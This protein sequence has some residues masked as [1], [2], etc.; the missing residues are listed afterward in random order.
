MNLLVDEIVS[1]EQLTFSNVSY[2][3]GNTQILKQISVNV[4]KDNKITGIVGPS[5]SG[6]TT[7]LR[8]VN[9]LISP[10]QGEISLNTN[11]HYSTLSSRGLRRK[12][13]FLQQ[14]PSL[15]PGTVKNNVEYGP[16]LWNINLSVK[17]INELLTKV[18]LD[19]LTYLN[20]ETSELSGGEQQRVCLARTLANKPCVLLLDEPTSSL[21]IVSE[22]IVEETLLKLVNEDGI[23]IIIVTHSLE[24]TKRLTDEIIFLKNGTIESQIP[25][26][27]F[28]QTYSEKQ[29]YN[30]FKKEKKSNDRDNKSN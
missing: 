2:S 22:G 26:K 8:L 5:G 12:I 13:G 15:F 24:Q 9:K 23:K 30:L 1:F 6:K 21:D 14:L 20:R 4:T 16:R 11:Y 29:I 28:F 27:E 25:T 18:D 7:F 19:P 17:E 10:T 3:V